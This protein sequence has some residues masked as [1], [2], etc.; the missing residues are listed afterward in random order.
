MAGIDTISF[1]VT[2]SCGTAR[3]ISVISVTAGKMAG[4]TDNNS[5]NNSDYFADIKVYPNPTTGYLTIEL[6]APGTAEIMLL[7]IDGKV[8]ATT[9]TTNAKTTINCSDMSSGMY[10]L[11]IKAGGKLIDKKIIVE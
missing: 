8:V 4:E 9:T 2:N 11:R 6:P 3:A 1:S 7:S 5:V 10:L